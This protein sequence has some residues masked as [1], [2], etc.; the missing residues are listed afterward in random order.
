M[1]EARLRPNDLGE[2]G[3]ERDDVMLDLALD[4]VDPR[5]VEHGV[6][7]LGPDRRRGLLRHDAERGEGIGRV[8]LDLEP[9]PE[10][11]LRVPDRG[12]LRP[13]VAGDHGAALSEW[14]PGS[15]HNGV[16]ARFCG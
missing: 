6:L 16:P 10:A 12:H 3:E 8:G 9:D 7:A 2:V 4:L 13:G 5:D 11:R 1:D 15:N 14:D